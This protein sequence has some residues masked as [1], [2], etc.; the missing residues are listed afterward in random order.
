MLLFLKSLILL[1]TRHDLV[2]ASSSITVIK[3]CHDD[4]FYSQGFDSCKNDSAISALWPLPVYSEDSILIEDITEEYFNT[5]TLPMEDCPEG[6]IAVSTS[7]FKL[8]SDGSLRLNEDGG[9]YEVGQFC[10]SQV[11]KSADIVIARFCA[12]DPCIE[13]NSKSAG[14]IRKCCP[15]RMELN[16]GYCHPS[17]FPSFDVQFKNELGEPLNQSLSSY[18]IRYGVAPKCIDD[19]NPLGEEF[20]NATFYILPNA[21]IFIPGYSKEHQMPSDFCIDSHDG[22]SF[23]I[24]SN[25]SMFF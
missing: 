9:N 11:F 21:Q 7:E 2:A 19:F 1:S 17:P 13:T 16:D 18:V 14:C 10:L 22:V 4:T 20:E 23:V 5:I 15:N 3:C 24:Y 12:S 8:I 25:A 6:Q